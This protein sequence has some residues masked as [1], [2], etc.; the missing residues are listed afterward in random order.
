MKLASTVILVERELESATQTIENI[1]EGVY[2][3]VDELAGA[4]LSYVMMCY[5]LHPCR[6]ISSAGQ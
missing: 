2:L 6:I 5:F 4:S 1:L 3:R